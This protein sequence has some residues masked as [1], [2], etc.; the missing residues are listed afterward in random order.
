[1]AMRK[2]LTTAEVHGFDFDD[3]I[4][5]VSVGDCKTG[6][7]LGAT[8]DAVEFEVAQH[9][10]LERVFFFALDQPEVHG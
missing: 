9:R 8:G 7:A 2:G 10:A 3:A 4:G 5:V 6:L 1:M